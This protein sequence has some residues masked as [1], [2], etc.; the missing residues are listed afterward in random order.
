VVDDVNSLSELAT[1]VEGVL[2]HVGP[3]DVETLAAALAERGFDLGADPADRL[4]NEVLEADDSAYL[5]LL[6]DRW[7]HLPSLVSGRTFTHR[8]TEAELAY[9]ALGVAPDLEPILM[10]SD[11]PAYAR[12]V[13]GTPVRIV[14]PGFPPDE[15]DRPIPSDALDMSGSLLLRSGALAGLGVAAGDLVGLRLAATGVELVRAGQFAPAETIADLGRRAVAMLQ[16]SPE[17]PQSIEAL[18]YELLADLPTAFVDPLPPLQELLAAWELPTSGD[19]VGVP[20]FDFVDWRVHRRVAL[21]RRRHELSEDEALAVAA[22]SRLH[23]SVLEIMDAYT[24]LEDSGDTTPLESVLE[25][26][27]TAGSK[28]R[29]TV[30]GLTGRTVAAT[31]PFLAEP[32]VAQAL[33]E[34]TGFRDEAGAAALGLLVETLEPQ[35]DRSARPALRW[36]RA[37]AHEQLGDAVAAEQE[38]RQAERLD[39]SWPPTVVDLARYA[40]D[41]GDA[42]AGLAL[43]GRIDDDA[44]P[45]L[46]AVLERH[47]PLPA[48]TMPRNDP[49]WCGS[50]RKFKQCH[51][52]R[53]ERPPLAERAGWI[54][55]KAVLYVF[56]TSWQ[57][58]VDDLGALRVEH[59]ESDREA[60]ELMNDGHVVDVT[61]FEG[62]A[63]DDFVR[64]RGALLPADELLL[65]EQWLFTERSVFEVTAVSPGAS[66]TVRDVRTGDVTTVAERTASR[67]LRPGQ[68]IC[69]H[70]LPTGDIPQLFGG[71]EPVALHERDALINLLDSEPE[72]EE[73]V[74]FCSR[75]FAPPIL[76]N[77]EGHPLVLCKAELRSDHPAELIDALDRRYQREEPNPNDPTAT[78]WVETVEVDGMHRIAANLRLVGDTLTIA[79]NSEARQDAALAAVRSLQPSILLVSQERTPLRTAR[80]AARLAETV[81]TR[82]TQ[83]IELNRLPEVKEAVAQHIRHYEE[84]WLD[85]PIPALKN[86]TPRQAAD[87]PTRRDDLLQLLATFPDTDDPLMMSPNR[88]RDALGLRTS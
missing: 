24:S 36:L 50:G 42:A 69:T 48:R 66:L 22:I 65:A 1:A 39:P 6:D 53:N 23:E 55:H 51:L 40:N 81:P 18:A 4:L 2:A 75:R 34:E 71:I 29:D 68:L 77:T 60:D 84:Q 8:V 44:A 70:L 45:A 31:L 87:D 56:A 74:E 80:D 9:D 37:R 14:L 47:R 67:E 64:G 13:D 63:L 33:L 62:G 49:C 76:A 88:L 28:P 11:Q 79:T 43:L 52:H 3:M 82:A 27:P 20:G 73:V 38:L 15:D 85:L 10:L 86:L 17:N 83:P 54:Y 16:A 78:E 5:P 25:A 61:L 58:L 26:I 30:D 46:R 59:V 35:A 32:A 57:E 7:F 12:F 21:L 41:R 19:L 72:P